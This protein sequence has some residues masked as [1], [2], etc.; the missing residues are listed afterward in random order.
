MVQF[1]IRSKGCH[2]ATTLKTFKF[3]HFFQTILEK[4]IDTCLPMKIDILKKAAINNLT[5]CA[6]RSFSTEHLPK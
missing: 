5:K 6:L 4:V 1:Q 3:D 2:E